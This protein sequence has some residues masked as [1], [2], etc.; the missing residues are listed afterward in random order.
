[1]PRTHGPGFQPLTRETPYSRGF[2]V[3][4]VAD[5]GPK[6]LPSIPGLSE[7]SYSFGRDR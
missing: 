4:G 5:P 6:A 3:A 2:I 7:P 1:M